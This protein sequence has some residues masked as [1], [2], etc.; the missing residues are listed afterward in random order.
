M[1]KRL[2]HLLAL[3]GILMLVLGDAAFLCAQETKSEEFTLEEITVTAQ[4]RAENQQKV[5]IAMEVLSGTQLAENGQNDVNE[6][7][8]DVSN[9]I[10]NMT[11]EGMRVTVRGINEA[12]S[13]FNGMRVQTPTVAINI[14][15]AYNTEDRAGSNLFDLER[16]EVLYGPQSTMYGSNSPGGIVNVVTASPKLDKYSVSGSVEYAKY[17]K[18]NTNIALNAPIVS[19]LLAMRL[20]GSYNKHGSWVKDNSNAAKDKNVRLKTLYQPN[21]DLSIGLTGTWSKM[22]SGGMMGGS[23]GAF[24]DQDNIPGGGTAWDYVAP[25]TG[26]MPPPAGVGG[27]RVT[28]GISSEI[29]Y[30]TTFANISIVPAYSKSEAHDLSLVE[31]LGMGPGSQ[32]LLVP[33]PQLMENWTKQKNADVRLTSPADSPIKWILGGTYYNS[34]RENNTKYSEYPT[35]DQIGYAWEKTKGIYGNITYPFTETFRGTAGYRFSWDSIYNNDG[36]PKTGCTGITGMDYSA[37]DYKIGMEYDL[38]QN[39][40][41][42]ANYATSYR[43][44]GMAQQHTVN[45]A[46]QWMWRAIPPEKLKAYTVGSKSRFMENKLQ[47]NASAY[48]YDYRN[49]EF[50]VAGD[51]SMI[52]GGPPQPGVT[53]VTV[54]ESDYCGKDRNGNV[55]PTAVDANGQPLCPDFNFNGVAGE[56]DILPNG[57]EDPQGKQVGKFESLGLDVSTNW[58][59]SAEDRLDVSLS[60]MHTKWKDATIHMLWWWIWTDSTGARVEN[61]NYNGMRNTFSPT[62]AGTIGYEHNFMVGNMGTLTPHVDIQ[63]KSPYKLN[64]VSDAQ[65]A[66]DTQNFGANAPNMVGWNKQEAY[67]LVDANVNFAHASGIWT[68]NAYIKNATNYAVKTTTAGFGPGGGSKLG[69]NDP[70]TF[71]AVLSVKF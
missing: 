20:A 57:A 10:I 32:T 55:V 22:N 30:N 43:V 33:T 2:I 37:P 50:P 45:P 56:P 13:A 40:M 15:G 7:L 60:Y 68:L 14:D 41:L 11:D 19:D 5:P 9:A 66:K 47:V 24:V 59:I 69:L 42:F 63:F 35:F 65:V 29:S 36:R 1:S 17:D 16:V 44:Q 62:W 8:K 26:G 64:L 27:A 38:A 28:K 4:K 18:L 70:R 48:Y 39:T 23:V 58:M 61:M 51:W 25:S 54:R 21:Q 46:A 53:P 31:N 67:Y 71:G 52:G 34:R 6:I 49:R 12:G 3:T